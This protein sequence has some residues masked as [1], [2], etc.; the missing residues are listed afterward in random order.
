MTTK[1]K[2]KAVMGEAGATYDTLIDQSIDEVSDDCASYC[3]LAADSAGSFATFG[4]ETLCA[5]WYNM[6]RYRDDILLLPWRP[7]V[8][9]SGVVENG[10]ALV[11]GSDYRV[12]A[13]GQLQRL[14]GGLPMV[15]PACWTVVVTMTAGWTLPAGVPAGLEGR[16][17]EQVRMKFMARRRDP[18]IRSESSPDVGA[19][20]YAVPGGD[21]IGR[22][23][24]LASLESALAPYYRAAVA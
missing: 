18:A 6:D 22:S 12:M 16:V 21:S 1:E 5:T 10:S 4:A 14:S 17:I 7:K 23:G 19:A 3:G 13:G 11:S 24:L 2:V 9:V 8:A 15:W 20:S